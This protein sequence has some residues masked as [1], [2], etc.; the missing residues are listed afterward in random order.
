MSRSDPMVGPFVAEGLPFLAFG[1]TTGLRLPSGTSRNGAV[2][3]SS[4]GACIP[5]VLA[6][7]LL[8]LVAAVAGCSREDIQ[9]YSVPKP[10]AQAPAQAMAPGAGQGMPGVKYTTPAGW[11]EVAPGEMR[12]ASF[13][14]KGEQ[15]K[16][17]DVGVFPLPGMAGGD[18]NNVNRWR[19]QVGQPA[20]SEEQ[21]AKLAEPVPVAGET[22]QLYDMAGENTTSGEKTRILAAILRREG[23]AW[24]FKVTGD[25]EL[26]AKQKPGFIEF[27]KSVSFTAPTEEGLPH[28]HPPIAGSSVG[29]QTELPPSHPPIAGSSVGG[30]TELPPSHP[31]ID[32]A[33]ATQ[34]SAASE[35]SSAGKP[36][37]QVPAGWKELAAGQFLVAK[38][39]ISGAD[40]AQATVNVSRSAGEGGGLVGNV[41]RWRAQLGLS[42]LSEAEVSKLAT[43][44]DTTGAKAMFVDMAGTDSK[45]GQKTRLIGAMV[46]QG[47]QTW[48]YKLMGNDQLVEREKAL[49]TQFVQSVK[50]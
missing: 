1:R 13:R 36:A 50:Y 32:G 49:F 16:Q 9:V 3:F 19:G 17:A 5:S 20:V 43:P 37:W 27:L 26:V 33:R 14:V 46:P 11:E 15:G 34:V 44:V 12:V 38:F 23:M 31:P 39:Q 25:D 47:Q 7:A 10:E 21:L 4:R 8:L 2:N 6:G 35:S 30:Q 41:N 28:S 18:L 40:S 22:A 29:G 42:A 48:F 45:T 24:F